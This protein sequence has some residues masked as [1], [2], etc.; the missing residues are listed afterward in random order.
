VL[1]ATATYNLVMKDLSQS[2]DRTAKEP[3]VERET[4]YYQEN[5]SKVKSIDDFLANDRL[6]R[7]AMKAHG[8]EDMTYAKA[9]MRK[10]LEEGT[11]TKTAFANKLADTRYRDFAKTFDFEAFGSATTVTSA[12]QQGTVDKYLRQTL[13]ED[14][15]AQNEGARLALYFERK[16]STVTTTMNLLGDPALLK[17]VQVAFGFSE[18][19]GAMDVDKQ[20]AMIEKRLDVADLQDPQK[21]KELLNRFTTLW[22]A[23]NST[24]TATSPAVLLLTQTPTI[25]VDLLSAIQNLR[26]GGS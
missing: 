23:E 12:A 14:V 18:A 15:G 17:V 20:V 4:A 8:L 22:E 2:L 10:V 19:T 11:H 25:G 5:I 9:F 21:L 7:Y 13:E 1:T 26:L 24:T 16:A 3:V 6:Y